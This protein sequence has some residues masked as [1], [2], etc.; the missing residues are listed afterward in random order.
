MSA[1]PRDLTITPRHPDFDVSEL[2]RRNRYWLDNDPVMSHFFNALQ[3]AFPEGE[4][5]FIDAARDMTEKLGEENLP[6]QLRKDVRH[7]IRQEAWHGKEHDGWVKALMS[8]GYTRLKDYN[9]QLLKQRL[10]SRKH[11]SLAL[12]LS[13]TAGAEHLTASL[14]SVLLKRPELLERAER[15]VRDILAWHTLEEIEHKSVCFDLLR[16]ADDG[17]ALRVAGLWISF[18]DMTVRVTQRHVYLLKKDGL[19]NWRTRL[20]MARKIWG[21]R[22][23][24]TSLWPELLRYMRPGFHPWDRDERDAFME[25]FGY[26]VRDLPAMAAVA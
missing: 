8:L 12:R 11:V 5:F 16:E 26:L 15:P 7:F 24:M 20:R 25:R 3:S 4:R 1:R 21:P 23:V 6:A 19:W 18:L 10:W 17:Y 9:R 2:L 22:G 13:A 14:A